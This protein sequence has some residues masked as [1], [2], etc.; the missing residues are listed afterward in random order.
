MAARAFLVAGLTLAWPLLQVL[1]LT[2]RFG[3]EAMINAQDEIAPYVLFGFLSGVALNF[4]LA[5]ETTRIMKTGVIGG[6]VLSVPIAQWATVLGGV[7][8]PPF[9]GV[10]LAGLVAQFLGVAIGRLVAGVVARRGGT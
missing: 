4:S 3:D 5:R 6:F 10:P 9:L 1:I 2:I 7:T 8:F